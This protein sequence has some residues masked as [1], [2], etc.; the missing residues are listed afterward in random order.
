MK[1]IWK[2]RLPETQGQEEILVPRG[3]KFLSVI[4]QFN[5]PTLYAMV[6]VHEPLGP[7]KVL[8]RWTGSMADSDFRD[9]HRFL[10]SVSLCNGELVLHIFVEKRNYNGAIHSF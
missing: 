5:V 7:T 10:G 9:T 3:A 6:D 8:T 1:S 4:E 2:F